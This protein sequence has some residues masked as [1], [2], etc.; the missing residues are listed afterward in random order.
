MILYYE[1]LLRKANGLPL[2]VAYAEANDV[3]YDKM[4]DAKGNLAPLP[5]KLASQGMSM[6]LVHASQMFFGF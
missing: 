5:E 6:P 3:T 2:R 1:N 4:F